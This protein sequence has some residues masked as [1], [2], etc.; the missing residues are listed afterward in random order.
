MSERIAS[1][2]LD[3]ST[4]RKRASEIEHEKR[5]AILDLLHSNAFAPHC[6]NAGPYALHVSVRE[7]R[8]VFDIQSESVADKKAQLVLSLQPLRSIIRDYFIVCE[9]YYALLGSHG[10]GRVEA[11]DMGRRSLH[12]EGAEML[13]SMLKGRITV[14]FPTARRLFTLICVLH[15]R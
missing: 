1:L 9:S 12:N 4:I 5:T 15:I 6:L 11:I 7:G 10:S 14:D 2:T 8:L 13:M 3:E